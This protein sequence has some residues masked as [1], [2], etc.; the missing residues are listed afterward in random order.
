MASDSKLENELDVLK[1]D[2]SKVKSDLESLVESLIGRGKS[3]S[4]AMADATRVKVKDGVSSVEN[5]IEDRPFTTVLV[6]LGV[7]LLVGK[8]FSK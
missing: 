2:M 5:Y 3:E 4:H 8:F 1:S 7:G 6:A